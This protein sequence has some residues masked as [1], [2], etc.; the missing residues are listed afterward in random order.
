MKEALKLEITK[1]VGLADSA[2]LISLLESYKLGD[3]IQIDEYIISFSANL[4]KNV[5]N[6]K[7]QLST[8]S[9][10]DRIF[11]ISIINNRINIDTQAQSISSLT[12]YSDFEE[13]SIEERTYLGIQE[14]H[15]E[16]PFIAKGSKVLDIGAGTGFIA[17][18]IKKCFDADVYALEPSIESPSD[19][20]SCVARL[21]ED[22][23]QKLTLQEALLRFP[24]KYFQAFDVVCVFKY[25]VPYLQKNDF[26]RA[27][28]QVVKPNG[29]VYV[30]SVEQEK[31]I[32]Q[33]GMESCHLTDTFGRYFNNYFLRTRRSFYGADMLMTL[34]APRLELTENA[35]FVVK[36][37]IPS[38][39][40]A[41]KVNPLIESKSENAVP[42]VHGV[43]VTALNYLNSPIHNRATIATQTENS[44]FNEEELE[45]ITTRCRELSLD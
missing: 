39:D 14:A 41:L 19:Y 11:P 43:P 7:K 22:H 44:E 30:T 5:E 40:N 17:N 34:S 37:D 29:V 21:G 2:R 35:S 26:I 20:K 45:S 1:Q 8:L 9:E 38:N 25:N 18:Q 12:T 6:L 36:G 28:S 4:V 31:F 32:L 27:L 15:V 42:Q 13:S 10:V 16:L 3:D 23:V 24:K 33:K